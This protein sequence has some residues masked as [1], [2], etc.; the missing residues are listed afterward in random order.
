MIKYNK[1]PT[2]RTLPK[3]IHFKDLYL[4]EKELLRWIPKPNYRIVKNTLIINNTIL[5]PFFLRLFIRSTFFESPGIK[6]IFKDTAKD[7]VR[8]KKKISVINKASWILDNKSPVYFH[9]ICDTLSR[10]MLIENHIKNYPV[11]LTHDLKGKK[12]IYEFLDYLEIPYIQMENQYYYIKELL[13]TNHTAPSGNY[14]PHLIR[15]LSSRFTHPLADLDT[16]KRRIWID[17]KNERRDIKN[18]DEVLEKLKQ[19]NFEIINFKDYSIYEKKKLMADT[20][21]LMGVFG[22]GLTNM[23]MLPKNANVI[24]LR[25]RDDSH[26]NAFFSLASELRL[27]YHYFEVDIVGHITHGE[28]LID[29]CKFENFLISIF[30]ESF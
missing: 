16:Q 26:N 28:V 22:S 9:F 14:N 27:P 25:N 8:S 29:I 15:K 30:G 4:F 19:F 13:L 6:K 20:E 24:E 2:I 21:F 10:S 18:W 11:L 7:L 3:N 5:K 23:I 12:F 17:R 1:T